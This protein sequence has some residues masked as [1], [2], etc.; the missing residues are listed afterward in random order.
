MPIPLLTPLDPSPNGHEVEDVGHSRAVAQE[1]ADAD[2]EH[3]GQHQ[4]LVPAVAQGRT[5]SDC[6]TQDK[7][8]RNWGLDKVLGQQVRCH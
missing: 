6:W 1:A 7:A 3:D 4:D 5:G 2:L 8:F